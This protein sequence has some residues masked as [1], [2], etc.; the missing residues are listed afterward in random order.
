MA[1]AGSGMEH[2]PAE[3]RDAGRALRAAV[4]R[5]A[6][7]DWSAPPGR[8]DPLAVLEAQAASRLS[9]LGP[10]RYERMAE[11]PFAFFRGAAAVMAMD[12]AGTPTT[13][14]RVQAC[15]DAHVNNF[16]KYASPERNLVFDINDFD[17][18]VPGPWEWDVKRLCTSL[19]VVARQRGF[20]SAECDRVV[21]A[22]ARSYRTRLDD[23]A[24]WPMLDLWYERTEIKDVVEHFPMRYRPS[25][26]RDAR[27]ARRKDHLRAVAKLTEV[28]GGRRRFI[29]DPP[30]VVHFEN[31]EHD[32]DEVT[33]LIDGYR[34]TLSDD[35]RYLFDRYRLLDVARKVV[36]VGS[37]GTRCWIGLFAGPD[38][39]ENDLIVLQV[40]EAQ[41]SVL[42]PYVGGSHLGH[43]GRRVVVGQ[44]LVQAA[45][46]IF[47]GWTE[48]PKTGNHYYLRQL[49]DFKG[50]GDPMVMDAAHLGAYGELCAW[51][52]ARSHAR[53][54]D[55]VQISGYLG[56]ASSFERAIAAFASGYAITNEADHA[57][58]VE[59]IGPGGS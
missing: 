11:S 7:G 54:G 48:G 57:A 26:E 56:N 55:A 41:A 9:E 51:I 15:G 8:S 20:S 38:D 37:V 53:T 42:E 27:R 29:E 1:D 46:D 16:G 58:L 4:P 47:L 44:R 40:K 12:L 19:H 5:S 25:V 49:W 24:A 6:H 18:T 14:I 35:R 3:R 13:G 2:S 23:Y 43:H 59:S 52:L 30:L 28:V 21:T 17:E 33:G 10:I 31:T 36:G 50:Q 22:A 32:L 39:P 34:S 45:S